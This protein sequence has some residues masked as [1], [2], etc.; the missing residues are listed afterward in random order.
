MQDR[1]IRCWQRNVLYLDAYEALRLTMGSSA[2]WGPVSALRLCNCPLKNPMLD[3]R[4]Q[5]L[6]LRLS[7]LRVWLAPHGCGVLLQD[8]AE[9]EQLAAEIGFPIMIKATAGGG[10]RGMRLV[11]DPADFVK[12]LNQAKSEAGAAF[13]ND[14]CYLEKYITNPRHIEFQVR[15]PP[16]PPSQPA[17][18]AAPALPPLW[19][20]GCAPPAELAAPGLM[21]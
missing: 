14:G 8:V 3:S 11:Q 5:A 10:G 16:A 6:A 20:A 13:G 12:L 21:R 17:E 7:G 1:S 15:P 2:Q 18:P 4:P 9:A 19:D